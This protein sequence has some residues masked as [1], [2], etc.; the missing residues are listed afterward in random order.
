MLERQEVSE[1]SI[2][3]RINSSG[4]RGQELAE[5][6]LPLRI[7]ALGDSCTFGFFGSPPWPEVVGISLNQIRAAVEVINAGVDG[8]SVKNILYRAGEFKKLEADI[9]LIYIGWNDIFSKS[10][11][12]AHSF[13]FLIQHC[14]SC[15]LIRKALQ[16]LPNLIFG[17]SSVAQIQY[18]KKKIFAKQENT[19]LD[20]FQHLSISKIERLITELK[21]DSNEIYLLT[22]PSLY[23]TSLV[24]D[25]KNPLE[26]ILTSIYRQRLCFG[27]SDRKL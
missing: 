9:I 4:Y 18:A 13:N 1:S 16:R 23:S 24:P 6:K 7:L 15:Q 10:P 26:R 2:A 20:H 25:Q 5:T 3:L 19:S 27:I 8:Y 12:E 14:K 11:F 21:T 17:T 22:L